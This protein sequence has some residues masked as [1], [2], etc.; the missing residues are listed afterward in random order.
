M[1]IAAFTSAA[2][3]GTGSFN[4]Q[5]ARPVRPIT[6]PD[7]LANVLSNY[8]QEWKPNPD[9][10]LFTTRNRRAPSS[11]KV[12]E[13]QLWP[14]LARTTLGYIHFRGGITEQAMADVSNSLKLDGVGRGQSKGSPYMPS[15]V[16][17]HITEDKM[18][19]QNNELCYRPFGRAPGHQALGG[20]R[21][22]RSPR[23]GVL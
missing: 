2:P 23:A 4:P 10:F 22:F 7:V 9:G 12:V 15:Q 5:R 17:K 14:I 11:N 3:R 21:K 18:I 19:R 8:K 6:L 16:G 1:A 20:W 13:Y